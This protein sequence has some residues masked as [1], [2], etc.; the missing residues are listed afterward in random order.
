MSEET[1]IVA[2]SAASA[3]GAKTVVCTLTNPPVVTAVQEGRY[4]ASQLQWR[5][6][7]AH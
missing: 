5:A 7:L 4:A 6:C 3:F 1:V 2:V